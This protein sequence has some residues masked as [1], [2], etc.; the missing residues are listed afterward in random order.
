MMKDLLKA[1]FYRLRKDVILLVAL[2]VLVAF[3]FIT[4]LMY[5][6]LELFASDSLAELEA[7]GFSMQITGKYSFASALSLTNNFGMILPILIGILVCKDFSAGT[8]RNKIITG[9][10]KASVYVSILIS[11]VALGAALFA[12]YALLTL[13]IGSLFLGY[14]AE[15]NMTELLYI[16][17]TLVMGVLIFAC[18][19]ALAVLL[20]ALTR[21]I[22]LTIVLEIA[23]ALVISLLGS[24]NSLPIALPD[25]ME[26][27]SRINPVYQIS[28]ASA[29]SVTNELFVTSLITSAVYLVLFGGIGL[30]IFRKADQK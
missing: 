26:K 7:M 23:A 11:S 17:K 10:S 12:L 13:G 16:L 3:A 6:A 15:F 2:I 18:A 20:G 14:G 24:L 30:I 5:A 21:S 4:P 25:W 8:V 19:C 1:D 22:G 28:L 29:G 27:V 9:H